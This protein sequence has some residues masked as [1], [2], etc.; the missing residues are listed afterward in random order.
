MSPSV[1]WPGKLGTAVVCCETMRHVPFSFAQSVR[2]WIMYGVVLSG[3]DWRFRSY[4]E[5]EAVLPN[6]RTRGDPTGV[7]VL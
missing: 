6:V 3:P 1:R 7:I 4:R 5:L 2:Y